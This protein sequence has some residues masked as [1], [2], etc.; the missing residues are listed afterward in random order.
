[1]AGRQALALLVGVRI[2]LSQHALGRPSYCSLR[3]KH[4]MPW[5]CRFESP[6]SGTPLVMHFFQFFRCSVDLSSSLSPGEGPNRCLP[7]EMGT[8]PLLGP[9][10]LIQVV[11]LFPGPMQGRGVIK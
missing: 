11:A 2:L 9:L 7:N 5:G 6:G 8:K 10:P 3:R 4:L 1:M